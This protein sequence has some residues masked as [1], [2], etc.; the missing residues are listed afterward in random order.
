M[1][2]SNITV[3]YGYE[4]PVEKEKGTLIYYDSFERA[5]EEELDR[6]AE[7]AVMYAFKMLVLYP[8]HEETVKRMAKGS[9]AAYYKRVN[10]LEQWARERGG[11]KAAVED[12]EGKRKKY[13]PLD[14]AL[15]HLTEKY[16]SPYF[17]YVTPETANQL[18]SFSSFTEWIG[19]LRLLLTSDPEE[20]HPRL[21][22]YAHRWSVAGR[23]EGTK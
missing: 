7:Y 17:L 8:L 5:T 19:K 6:A 20:T 10:R 21:R 11:A 9:V 18:A 16:P 2:R 22:Q 4:P 3:S 1:G 13:T 14:A 12:W 23:S 15:R